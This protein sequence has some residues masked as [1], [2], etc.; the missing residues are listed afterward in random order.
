MRAAPIRPRSSKKSPPESRPI[1]I[2]SARPLEISTLRQRG[3][4]VQVCRHQAGPDEGADQVLAFGEVDPDLATDGA[5][6]H[7]EKG[8]RQHDEVYAPHVGSRRRSR[9]VPDHPAT[10]GEDGAVT[11][12]P[13]AGQAPEGVCVNVQAL[14]GLAGG[15]LDLPRDTSSRPSRRA[16]RTRA[17]CSGPTVESVKIAQRPGSSEPEKISGEVD[18]GTDED[19]VRM[20]DGDRYRLDRQARTSSA[21]SS[22]RASIGLD[23]DVCDLPVEGEAFRVAQPELFAA[24]RPQGAARTTSPLVENVRVFPQEDR[25]HVAQERS[26]VGTDYGTTAAGDDARRLGRRG[27]EPSALCSRSLKCFSPCWAKISGIP[28]PA[29]F[30]MARSRSTNSQAQGTGQVAGPGWSCR[31]PCTRR[32]PR[33]RPSSSASSPCSRRVPCKRRRRRGCRSC[34]PCRT[35]RGTLP[36]ARSRP[37]TPLSPLRPVPRRS[38][39]AP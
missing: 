36:R 38:R 39:R 23:L 34:C 21:T 24:C 15:N 12:Q 26:V 3:D 27:L 16:S 17:A 1:L 2:V 8:S 10:E 32:W 4:P 31:Y 14:G 18:A 19:A 22:G 29:L 13:H 35:S 30:T 6:H 9:Q 20:G 37:W 25:R 28:L 33:N 7:G 11:G 5:V